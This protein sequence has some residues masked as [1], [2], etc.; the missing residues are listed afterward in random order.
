MSA[1]PSILRAGQARAAS[2]ESALLAKAA[3]NAQGA[4]QWAIAEA[5]YTQAADALPKD[6]HTGRDT[7][8][9]QAYRQSARICCSM[10][11]TNAPLRLLKDAPEYGAALKQLQREAEAEANS[12]WSRA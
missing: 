4:L 5:L 9:A 1:L 12:I 6:V 11:G 10:K 8:Q 2:T 3:K 7:A